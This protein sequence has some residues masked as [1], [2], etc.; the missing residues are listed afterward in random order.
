[1]LLRD[2]NHD[3]VQCRVLV[4]MK[5]AYSYVGYAHTSCR[6]ALAFLSS[7]SDPEFAVFS[8]SKNLL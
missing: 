5:N 3:I 1:M 2:S 8:N 7:F 6:A 4:Y